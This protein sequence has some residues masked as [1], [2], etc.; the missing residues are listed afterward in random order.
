MFKACGES[1]EILRKPP[2]DF[3][4]FFQELKTILENNSFSSCKCPE[5]FNDILLP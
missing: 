2:L 3:R 4:H 1:K 5:I